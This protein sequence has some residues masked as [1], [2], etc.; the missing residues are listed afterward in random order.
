M[1]HLYRSQ[2]NRILAGVCGGLGEYFSIDPVLVRL[3][4]ILLTLVWGIGLVLYV[5]AW[6]IIPGRLDDSQASAEADTRPSSGRGRFWWGL[7][8]VGCGVVLWGGIRYRFSY[9]PIMPGLH[10][11][12]PG[13]VPLALVV[14]GLYLLYTFGRASSKDATSEGKHLYRS[15][16]NKRIGGVCGG[17]AEYFQIDATLVRVLFVAG[18]LF[19]LATGLIYLVLMI[20]L[21]EQPFEPASASPSAASGRVTAPRKGGKTGKAKG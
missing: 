5:V 8:L 18:S 9:W 21:Q 3:G 13:I 2:D 15:R 12:S 17:I 6:F 19:Y 20:S 16:S 10:L 11:R 1:K 7:V 14:V 4:W